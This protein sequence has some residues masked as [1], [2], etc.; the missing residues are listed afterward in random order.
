[1]SN[2][3]VS[4]HIMKYHTSDYVKANDKNSGFGFYTTERARKSG[5]SWFPAAAS[6]AWLN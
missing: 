6:T 2:A 1:M 4:L 3:I 5:F